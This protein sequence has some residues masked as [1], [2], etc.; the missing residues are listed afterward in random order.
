MRILGIDPGSNATGY[1][2]VEGSGSKLSHISHG[3]L[4]PPSNR[5]SADRLAYL[6]TEIARIVVEAR[7]EMCVIEQ[8]FVASSPRSAL[9]L[10]QAR[11]VALAALAGG[12]V[13]VHEVSARAVKKAVVGTGAATKA[14]VQAM[15]KRLLG[16]D[17]PPPVDAA[18]ALAIAISLAHAGKLL[19]IGVRSGRGRSRS[20]NRAHFAEK[21]RRQ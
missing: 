10:G 17:A 20:S 1:G 5:S 21:A 14:Q 2:V 13:P 19:E 16:L 6:H 18:D 4:R 9:I 15:V 3:I 7:P 8:V 11:G 12:G